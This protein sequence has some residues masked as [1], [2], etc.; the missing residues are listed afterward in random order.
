MPQPAWKVCAGI[1]WLCVFG[2]F[3]FRIDLPNSSPTVNRT[4][5]WLDLP[6]LLFYSVVRHPEAPAGGWAYFP[7]RLPIVFV[8]CWMLGGVWGLGHLMLRSLGLRPLL[9]RVEKSVFAFGLGL[10]GVSL[11]VLGAGLLAQRVPGALSGETL[12]IGLFVFALIE[13]AIRRTWDRSASSSA[14][15]AMPAGTGKSSSKRA[16]SEFSLSRLRAV[17]LRGQIPFG[18]LA[19]GIAGLAMGLFVAAMAL[20]AMLPSIDFDVKEYHLQGPKEWFVNG[21]IEMLPHNV[22]TSFPFLTEMFHLLGMELSSDWYLGALA[23]KLVLMTFA[24]LTGLAVF[25]AADRLFDRRAAWAAMLIHLSTPW[26]YRISIIAYAEGGL[27]FFLMATVLAVIIRV[28]T[29]SPD[30]ESPDTDLPETQASSPNAGRFTLLIGLLSGSAMACKYPGLLSVVFPAAAVLLLLE[31][32]LQSDAPLARRATKLL[33]VFGAGVCITIGPWLLKN[34]YETGNPVYPLMNSVFHGIDWSPTLEANWKHAHGPPHYQPFDLLVKFYDVTLKSD[35]LSPLMFSLAPLAFL[36]RWNR[37]LIG[38]L[39]LYVGFLFLSW[40]VLT[41][42]LDRFWIPLI[43]VVALLAGGGVWWTTH[44]LWRYAAGAFVALCVL[45]NLG[46]ITSVNCG[47]NTWLGDLTEV[48]DESEFTSEPVAYLNRMR[49]PTDAKVLFV[50]EAQVFDARVPLV[51]NT[52][53]DI[54]IFEQWCSANEPGVPVAEQKMKSTEEIRQRLKSEG[55]THILVNWQEV[56]RYR[57]TYG[58]SEFLAPW[59]FRH[60]QR[61]GILHQNVTTLSGPRFMDSFSDSDRLEI[62]KWAPEL[63]IQ[64]EGKPAFMTSHLFLV[65]ESED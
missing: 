63:I 5:V 40:W 60:L 12:G 42:R 31:W 29:Q 24:P 48:R 30:T 2:Y 43:P 19:R 32:K 10:S 21:A 62:E 59:R 16:D 8:G 18:I 61:E 9:R 36:T 38:S 64:H 13:F 34:L 35:W 27:S 46:F 22:Y 25:A 41:H 7:Q 11:L 26:T 54:S 57:T 56:L 49:L 4:D 44:K 47:L 1:I 28:Q 45:F 50:G 51:Y 53:F 14:V 37:R 3:F 52:V 65:T 58:I 6:D 39:W 33:A 15:S 23:G 17:L 20:G 55:I